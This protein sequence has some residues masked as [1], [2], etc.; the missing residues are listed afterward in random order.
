MTTI[1]VTLFLAILATACATTR[2]TSVWKDPSYQGVPHKILVIGVAKK[3]VNKRIFED[4]VVKQLKARGT[5]AV[6]GYTIMGDKKQSDH[7]VVAAAMQKQGADAVLISRMVSKKTV[8]FY[9]PG[10]VTYPPD[11]YRHWRE[12]YGYGYQTIYTP[13]Y[14][15]EDEFAVAET[16]LYDTRS[17]KLIWSAASETEIQGSDQKLIKSY[18]GTMVKAL[19]EEKL[20]P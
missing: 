7:T 8:E 11:N 14:M 12:Y 5:D 15:A 2:L 16:N 13:G 3:Q 10:S 1:C 17:E 19:A 9:V 18:I 6:A 4:E 20:L